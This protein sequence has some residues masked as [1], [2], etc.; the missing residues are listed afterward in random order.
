MWITYDDGEVIERALD[1]DPTPASVELLADLDG[2]RLYGMEWIDRIN[3]L[4]YVLVEEE[5]T[6]L[7]VAGRNGQWVLRLLFPDREALGRAYEHCSDAGLDF[8]VERVFDIDKGRQSRYGLTDK[9]QDVLHSAFEHGYYAIPR[10][11][12]AQNLAVEMDIS[13]QAL[14]ERLRRAHGT[15]I[16]NTVMLGRG[17]ES[18]ERG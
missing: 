14:S 9:Q 3:A 5:G 2:E 13:H 15:I 18:D 1:A 12:S 4:A 10:E 6:V 16:E 11:T 8:S 17:G 7:S